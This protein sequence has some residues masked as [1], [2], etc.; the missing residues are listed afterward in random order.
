M[1]FL[2]TKTGMSSG[3]TANRFAV[4]NP[5]PC[6]L[7]EGL[8]TVPGRQA[9]EDPDIQKLE[10]R[11]VMAELRRKT[12]EAERPLVWQARAPDL[13][14]RLSGAEERLRQLAAHREEQKRA[15][16]KILQQA[17]TLEERVK[18]IEKEAREDPL[19][20][21]RSKFKCPECGAT[22]FFVVELVCGMC[23]VGSIEGGFGPGFDAE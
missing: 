20:G 9:M 3:P 19:I 8:L 16:L 1:T 6:R 14:R 7:G 10:R 2:A 21:S 23:E 18:R 4:T 12:R 13:D 11:L 22:R 17:D 5:V 15:A